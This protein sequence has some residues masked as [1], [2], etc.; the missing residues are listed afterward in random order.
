MKE[1]T[2]ELLRKYL[3]DARDQEDYMAQA[4]MAMPRAERIAYYGDWTD[5]TDWPSEDLV[6]FLMGPAQQ[7]LFAA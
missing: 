5:V 6:E 3:M 1:M 4:D 2:V 7:S